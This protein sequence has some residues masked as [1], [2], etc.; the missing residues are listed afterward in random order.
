MVHTY[1]VLVNLTLV[2]IAPLAS[3]FKVGSHIYAC[4]AADMVH[5]PSLVKLF[6]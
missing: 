4:V 6:G 5:I 3:T 2:H 1:S